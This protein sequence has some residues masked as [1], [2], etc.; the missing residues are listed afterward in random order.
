MKI[1]FKFEIDEKVFTG[2]GEIGVV[3][4]LGYD[5][6]GACY[7]VETKAHGCW[8]KEKTLTK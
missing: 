5:D 2:F 1:E 7:F 6:G 3:K 4:M 8:H